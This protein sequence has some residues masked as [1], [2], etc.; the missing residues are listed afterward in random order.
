M[1]VGRPNVG[2]STLFNRVTR[3]RRAI[4]TP[5]PGTTRDVLAQPVEWQGTH[6]QLTDTG[7]MF[8][9]SEDPLH[10]LVLERGRRAIGDADLLV[11]VVDGREGLVGGDREI[12]QAVRDAGKPA[13]LAVNKTDD[14]RAR[15]G[16]L[17]MYQLGFDPVFE[18]AAE[19][20]DGVG[21]LLDA[22]VACA[23][24]RP[25]SLGGQLSN[26]PKSPSPSSVGR[27]P[28]SPRWSIGYFAKSG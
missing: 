22:I 3:S 6:F 27:M 28:A 15:S 4:V 10:E 26:R 17:E 7:G 24:S 13:L 5:V 14:R 11:L 25:A 23:P 18:I 12:A 1:L 16:A 2:K 20:G 8:G 9:A 21:D 19:H